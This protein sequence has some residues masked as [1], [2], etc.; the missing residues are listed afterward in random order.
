MHELSIA[1]A[2]VEAACDAAGRA[3]LRRV[4]RLVCCVGPLRMVEP[5]LLADAFAATRGGTLC[6]AAELTV[7]ST[8][9]TARCPACNQSFPIADDDWVCP[10]CGVEGSLDGGGD[11]CVLLSIDGEVD[12]GAN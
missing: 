9:L 12:H 3:G 10:R 7:N 5:A 2:L 11:E 6:A 8:G 1:Q 4:T